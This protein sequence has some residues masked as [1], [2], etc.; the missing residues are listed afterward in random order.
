MAAKKDVR[1]TLDEFSFDEDGNLV[2]D[3]KRVKEAIEAQRRAHDQDEESW[4][5]GVIII[6]APEDDMET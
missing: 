6:P 4:G 2:I 5:I 3:S 1:V